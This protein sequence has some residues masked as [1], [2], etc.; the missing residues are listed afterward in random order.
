MG[1][2]PE[3]TGLVI[4]WTFVDNTYMNNHPSTLLT[5]GPELEKGLPAH[6]TATFLR[7]A[8]LSPALSGPFEP[9]IIVPHTSTRRGIYFATACQREFS[10]VCLKLIPDCPVHLYKEWFHTE[11]GL[12]SWM[13]TS[14]VRPNS[15]GRHFHFLVLQG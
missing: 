12:S 6:R 3:G 13:N 14:L 5:L 4:G 11:I 2:A 15:S 8:S 7:G 10:F 1:I 9:I